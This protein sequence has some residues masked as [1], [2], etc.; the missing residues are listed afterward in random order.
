MTE[1][2]RLGVRMP[3]DKSG[4]VVNALLLRRAMSTAVLPEKAEDQNSGIL[5]LESLCGGTRST[6]HRFDLTVGH[7]SSMQASR[8]VHG[9]RE[10]PINSYGLACTD[11]GHP[12]A[13]LDA[14][15]AAVAFSRRGYHTSGTAM[16]RPSRRLTPSV[17][18]VNCTS[19]TRSSAVDAE[20]LIPCL[21]KVL[22][23]LDHD[24]I[25]LPGWARWQKL[26]WRLS[27]RQTRGP[28]TT[29]SDSQA[30]RS[31]PLRMTIF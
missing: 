6:N 17:S 9:M 18:S 14:N 10:R 1:S 24:C 16:T 23:V 20:K 28:S 8:S 25:S 15:W 29:Q 27:C 13:A 30:N 7:D 19:S 3:L 4:G 31:A 11:Q 5:T 12:R 22:P 2:P 26:L 21:H